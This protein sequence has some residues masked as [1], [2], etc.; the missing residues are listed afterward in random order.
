MCSAVLAARPASLR[1][2]VAAQGWLLRAERGARGRLHLA[3][4]AQEAAALQRAEVER[5]EVLGLQ[6]PQMGWPR[7]AEVAQG[8][9]AV[10]QAELVQEGVQR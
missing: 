7:G 9:G 3:R 6:I 1:L 10:R 2:L 4:R 8:R 5:A